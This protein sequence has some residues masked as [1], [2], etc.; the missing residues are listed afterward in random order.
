MVTEQGEKR[1][2]AVAE[3]DALHNCPDAEVTKTEEIALDGIIEP[4]DEKTDDKQKHRALD[5][6]TN[7]LWRGFELRFHQ[8]EVTRDTHDEEEEGEHEVAR[9]HAIPFGVTEHFKGFPPAVV[10]QYHTSD[11]NTAENVE[12]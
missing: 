5:N 1:H 10:H 12:T 3:G 8:R 6:T 4:V 2:D 11:S 7:D 9:R